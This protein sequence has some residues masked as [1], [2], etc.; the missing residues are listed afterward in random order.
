MDQ[1]LNNYSLRP[2]RTVVLGWHTTTKAS[3]EK[4]LLPL[5]DGACH[6]CVGADAM[7]PADTEPISLRHLA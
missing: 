3:L 1:V 6:S 7:G 2:R 4:T 5:L